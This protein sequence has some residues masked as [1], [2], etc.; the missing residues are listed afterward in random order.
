VDR[1]S[2]RSR[3][4]TES[5]R[6]PRYDRRSGHIWKMSSEFSGGHERASDD[7]S[8]MVM[9]EEERAL[10]EEE[11]DILGRFEIE[12]FLSVYMHNE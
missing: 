9:D 8:N 12:S 1:V 5:K 7:G 4:T 11:S 3:G 6:L 2:Q 10:F